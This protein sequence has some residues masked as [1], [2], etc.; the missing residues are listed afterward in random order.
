MRGVVG[1]FGR[2]IEAGER[3]L[4]TAHDED[5]RGIKRSPPVIV[6]LHL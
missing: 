3:D 2:A 6:I 4:G 5:R 1:E